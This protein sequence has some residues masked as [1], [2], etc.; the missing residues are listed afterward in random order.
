MMVLWLCC[1]PA[2]HV[3]LMQAASELS[4]KLHV[5]SQLSRNDRGVGLGICHSKYILHV[6][7]Q[8]LDPPLHEAAR[9]GDADRVKA[10]LEGG[11]DPCEADNRGR[12]PYDVAADK[13]VRDAFRR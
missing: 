9:A 10:L 2:S 13:A 8:E 11:S 3:V 6:H 5:Y 7:L 1:W 12:V 4:L